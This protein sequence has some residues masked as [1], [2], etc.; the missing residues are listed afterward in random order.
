[1]ADD[2]REQIGTVQK[3]PSGQTARCGFDRCGWFKEGY[4]TQEDAVAA[5]KSHANLI[6]PPVIRVFR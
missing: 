6:H 5:L 3:Q 1:M 4:R 2:D